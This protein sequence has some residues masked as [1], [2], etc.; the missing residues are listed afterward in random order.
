MPVAV[1]CPRCHQAV[2]ISDQ[3]AG[4]RVKCPHCQQPFLAPGIAPDA[5]EDDD[6]LQWDDLGDFAAEDELPPPPRRATGASPASSG[7]AGPASRKN[8]THAPAAAPAPGSAP[9]AATPVELAAEFRVRCRVCDSISH[10]KASQSGTT[11]TCSDCHSPMK[12]PPPPKVRPRPVMNLDSAPTFGLGKPVTERRRDD[13]PMRKSARELLAEAEREETSSSSYVHPDTPDMGQWFREV[14]GVFRDRG[15]ITHWVGLSLIAAVPAAILSTIDLPLLPIVMLPLGVIIGSVVVAEA[16]AVL[17][18]VANG[19]LR[20]AVWPLFDP[21]TWFGELRFGVVA[22]A[23]LGI[24][25]AVLSH[26]LQLG[27]LGVAITM[28]AVYALFPLLLLSMMDSNSIWQPISAEVARSVS[29][30]RDEWGGFYL[31]SGILYAALFLTFVIAKISAWGPI[32]AVLAAFAVVGATFVYFAMIGRLA[33][34]SGQTVAL[35]S[36]WESRDDALD[37]PEHKPPKA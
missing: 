7:P 23:L 26:L 11:I 15:V 27:L 29:K 24:P 13:D 32:G 17:Q 4:K 2:S 34:Q 1:Q 20:V 31:T 19:Q 9:P 14:F 28:L 22:A 18:A 35:S 10:V 8:P 16:F 21:A 5:V 37:S 33:Y 3:A 36:A 25:L 30:C 12:V 6:W